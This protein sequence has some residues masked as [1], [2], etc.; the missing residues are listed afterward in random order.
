MPKKRF[1]KTKTNKRTDGQY[2]DEQD[3]D[4]EVDTADEYF[5]KSETGV[6]EYGD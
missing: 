6:D 4:D 2:G 3:E 5:S 1:A